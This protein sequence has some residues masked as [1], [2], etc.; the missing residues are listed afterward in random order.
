MR[1]FLVFILATSM[2]SLT[3][4]CTLGQGPAGKPAVS[5]DVWPGK[6]PG[7][8]GDIPEEGVQPDKVPTARKVIRITNVSRPTISFFP[9]PKEKN[10]GAAVLVCPGGGYNILAW[11]LEGEEVAAWLNSIG[12]NA[13]VLKYRVPRRK[14]QVPH[15]APL[16]DAQRA[17]SLVRSKAGEWNLDAKRLGILGF[18]AGGH[19]SATTSTNFDKRHYESLD[20]VDQVSCRPDF[21]VLIYPAYLTGK[22]QPLSPEIRVSKDTPPTFFAHAG[23]DKIGPD[24]S[25][26]LYQALNKL[27]IPAEM[28]VYASG[29]H[30]FGLRPS[31]HPCATWPARCEDWLRNRGIL[32]KKAGG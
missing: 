27:G 21:A 31:E 3:T 9:A 30:G 2:V 17:M 22:D 28:H 24:N 23:D 4:E 20:A 10:T 6:A 8:K 7:E 29:G 14:D 32:P 13:V 15:L 16:Q 11:D 19:L 1:C 12:V 18:S 5:L 25:I 26:A